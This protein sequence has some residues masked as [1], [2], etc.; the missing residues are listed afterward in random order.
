M[1]GWGEVIGG[2]AIATALAVGFHAHTEREAMNR[3]WYQAI[4]HRVDVETEL[5]SENA[6]LRAELSELRSYANEINR[7]VTVM[8]FA[9]PPRQ[10]SQLAAPPLPLV[11]R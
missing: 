7:A 11:E 5:R 9:A 10:R 3:L 1:R 4:E 2:F 6:A 8:W